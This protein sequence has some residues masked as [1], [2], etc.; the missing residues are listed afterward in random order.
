MC[1]GWKEME[2]MDLGEYSGSM[3]R[4]FPLTSTGEFHRE[5]GAGWIFLLCV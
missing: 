2:G 1:S 3:W 4:C 5:G